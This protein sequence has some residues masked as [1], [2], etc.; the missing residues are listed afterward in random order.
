[1]I[2]LL[3]EILPGMSATPAQKARL[4]A[5]LDYDPYEERDIE[6]L[7]AHVAVYFGVIRAALE[8]Y[9]EAA[10]PPAEKSAFALPR[11]PGKA[12]LAIQAVLADQALRGIMDVLFQFAETETGTGQAIAS[13]WATMH[14]AELVREI[15]N[16][17]QAAINAAISDFPMTPGMTIA[18]IIQRIPLGEERALTI[19]TTEVTRAYAIGQQRAAENIYKLRPRAKLVKVWFT[20]HD[21]RVCAVCGPLNRK[22]VGV[23]AIWAVEEDGKVKEL[24]DAFAAP[25]TAPPAHPRCRCRMHIRAALP[26]EE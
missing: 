22:K 24:T 21:D 14:A 20:R 25:L 10:F 2:N 17:T 8:A 6:R 16:T 13:A 11:I 5:A 18:D 4:N 3:A 9:L 7:K 19:A 1:M 26:G 23:D 12:L 15:D